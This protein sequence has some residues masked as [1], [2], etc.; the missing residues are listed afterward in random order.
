MGVR[1]DF[2]FTE[3]C[4]GGE[5]ECISKETK[6]HKSDGCKSTN[7]SL[8]PLCVFDTYL[9]TDFCLSVLTLLGF[10]FSF[11]KLGL[12]SGFFC[13]KFRRQ[14]SKV[15]GKLDLDPVD[16]IKGN[17]ALDLAK[18]NRV[19]AQ[20]TDRWKQMGCEEK[21]AAVHAEMK[22]V[23]QLPANSSYAT[24][25]LRVLNKVLQLMSI[26]RTRSQDEELELLF[27]GLSL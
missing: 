4:F 23:N 17:S 25:R 11:L 18:E 7:R 15:I 14:V 27:A 24:H 10:L 22:R 26:Q 1:M 3:S 8:T 19:S 13:I 2:A 6:V 12:F 5:M 21:K 16:D 9:C 20:T